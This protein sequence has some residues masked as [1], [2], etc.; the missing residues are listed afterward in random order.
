MISILLGACAALFW[1]AGTLFLRSAS[2]EAEPYA[3]A[4]W[5]GFYN[6]LLVLVPSVIVL[7]RDGLDASTVGLGVAAGAATTIAIASES[8]ALDIS[9]V[10]T[11]APLVALEG[12]AAAGLGILTGDPVTAITAV[13]LAL[14]VTGGLGVGLPSG[15]RLGAPGIGWAVLAAGMFGISLWVI[16]GT[17]AN[18]WTLLLVLNVVG[19]V[20][21]GT[22]FRRE[23]HPTKMP[24]RAHQSLMLLA[25]MNI[26]GMLSFALGAR[27]GSLPI[28]SV[29]AAQFAI[30]AI[31]G[32][33]VLHKERL[34]PKQIAGAV[35]LLAG[36]GLLA[37]SIG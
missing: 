37:A 2:K 23:L 6:L 9:D 8:R 27:V 22:L 3:I 19:V 18:I 31:V 25:V 7:A 28:T 35:V 32:G 36:V 13:G 33:Y 16:G 24:W 4:F 1:G 15:L 10:V 12:A 5:Y 14:C 17:D 34:E 20:V 29:I 21:L 30:P 11:I 26:G